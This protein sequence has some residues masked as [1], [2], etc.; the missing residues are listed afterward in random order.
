MSLRIIKKG[1]K[2][3][4]ISDKKELI[5]YIKSSYS[6]F[7]EYSINVKA[8]P[9]CHSDYIVKNGT[10]KGIQ[11]YI[12]KDCKKNFNYKTNT[13]L[14][15][16][17]KLNKWNEFVDDFTSL[18][19]PSL[20]AMSKKLCISEQ[21]AFNWRQKLLSAIAPKTNITFTEEAIEFDETWLRLSRKGRRNMGIEDPAVYR[22]WR[23][24]Q[25]GDSPYNVKVF[26]SSGRK[27]K[28]LD[29]HQ[30]HTGR[31]SRKDMEN[32]F[33]KDKFKD[34]SVFSDAHVTYK[35]FFKA[36]NI[37]HQT[38]IG[39]NHISFLN[40]EV[41]NQTANSLIRGFK[42]FVNEHMRG[43]STKYLEHYIKWYQ[44]IH[45]SKLQM[46]KKDELKFN[47]TD[48]I[49]DTIAKDKF[50]IELY[51]QSELSFIRF[52]KNN[53]RTNHGDCKHHYYANKMAA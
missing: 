7:D 39:K 52:L 43:V 26:F 23:K 46:H 50:G 35:S 51:R 5:D 8:C 11:K 44:F 40:K 19:I 4:S 45:E 1:I 42:Y 16:V 9:E 22:A 14:S 49:C 24:K 13:V 36:N 41:H 17:Q 31:T 32:Y 53:G 3:L 30:S 47:V 6:V 10:R 20:K 33:I 2:H 27:S 48:E 15:K 29:V 25:V 28:K 21:T 12:C 37:E 18:N 38:F 34:I